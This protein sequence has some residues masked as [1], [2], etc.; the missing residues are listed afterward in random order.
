[1]IQTFIQL[2]QT[3]TGNVIT[4]IALLLV[5]AIIGY[6]TS[7]YYAKSIYTPV[8]KGLE[9]D[10][11]GLIKEVDGLKDDIK[12]LEGKIDNLTGQIASLEEKITAKDKEL[13]SLKK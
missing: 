1:M 8:I 12:K 5:A 9:A 13:K 3:V 11:A 2:A 7:W 4:I 6:F 10:K